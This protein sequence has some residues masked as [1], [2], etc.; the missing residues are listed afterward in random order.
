MQPPKVA[1]FLRG[2]EEL[3]CWKEFCSVLGTR[4]S[5]QVL[6]LDNCKLNEACLSVLW[7]ALAQ[8]TCTPHSLA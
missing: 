3:S 1:V 4:T 5:L 2:S 7:N 8:P 6:D